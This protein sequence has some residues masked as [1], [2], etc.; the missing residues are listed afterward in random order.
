ML[1]GRR[2]WQSVRRWN[3]EDAS[4]DDATDDAK[5]APPTIPGR[6]VTDE[7]CFLLLLSFSCPL[8][9][10]ASSGMLVNYLHGE[11]AERIHHGQLELCGRRQPVEGIHQGQLEFV[12]EKATCCTMKELQ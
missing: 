9:I 12:W 11:S 5:Q 6:P 7:Q 3:A 10:I 1:A 2:L 8:C 4:T